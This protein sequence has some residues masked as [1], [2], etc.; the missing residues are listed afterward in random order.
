VLLAVVAALVPATA[1]V[2]AQS[3]PGPL[4]VHFLDAGDGDAAWAVMPDGR[5]ILVDCGP[6]E[7][8][9]QL[10]LQLQSAALTTIDV[11]APSRA[12][13]DA[14]GGC[15]DV[16]R[17]FRV[18]SVL[19]SPGMNPDA[20]PMVRRLDAELTA[21]NVERLPG[22]AGWTQDFGTTARLTLFNPT[23]ERVGNAAGDSQVLLLEY[24]TSGLL[25]AGGVHEAGEAHVQRASDPRT[26]PS[27]VGRP[28]TVLRAADHGAAGTS[29]SEF[30]RQLFP[31][32]S[33]Q[34]VVVSYSPVRGA[35]QLQADVRERLAGLVWPGGQLFETARNGSI[36]LALG[37]DGSVSSSMDR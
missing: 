36:T 6:P 16:V 5:T 18:R 2:H 33:A 4:E 29:N 22:V 7:T 9:K 23:T 37:F 1:Q 34:A 11:L 26:Q 30:L 25:F 10:L 24:G 14:M 8:S 32:G 28:I 17:Y 27:L 35:P 21:A 12:T 20:S 31:T 19:W 15:T 3:Q 13:P